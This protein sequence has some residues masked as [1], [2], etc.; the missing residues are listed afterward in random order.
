MAISQNTV[1]KA[2]A[3]AFVWV[4]RGVPLIVQIFVWFNIAL[5]VPNLVIGGVTISIN[6]I[7][8][9]PVRR[10]ARPSACTKRPTWPK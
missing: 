7:V 5:F 8:S 3:A 6:D 4:I 10:S 2:I 1:L 9:P